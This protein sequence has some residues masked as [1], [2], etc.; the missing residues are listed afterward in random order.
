[1][2]LSKIVLCFSFLAFFTNF[3]FAESDSQNEFE[4]FV[5]FMPS[6]GAD[7]QSGGVELIEAGA[8][9]SHELKAFGKLPVKFSLRDNYIGIENSTTVNLPSHLVGLSTDIESTFPYFGLEN[10]YIRVGISPSF[11]AD[12][13]DFESSN[14]RIPIRSYLI[15][16]PDDKWTFIGGIGVYPDYAKALV[17]IFGFIYKPDDKWTF[18]LIPKNPG[19]TY[20]LSERIS[21]FAEAGADFKEFEVEKENL[22][23]VILSYRQINAGAG[24]RYKLN[25][26]LNASLSSGAV[27]N[28]SI[29][30]EDS[31]GKVSIKDGFY[32]ESRIQSRF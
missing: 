17:P 16:K 14:F 28:R 26:F 30:Y 6:K 10:I 18:N 5:K 32:L 25:N 9:Y 1:M 21:L 13:Y 3:C 11:Y 12:S 2:K 19:I 7:A 15:Y 22:D 4:V 8:E 27:F 24:I 20:A 31:L 23:N 29:K